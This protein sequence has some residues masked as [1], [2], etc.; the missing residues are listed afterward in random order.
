M[1]QFKKTGAPGRRQ[2][3]GGPHGPLGTFNISV[4]QCKVCQ[5]PRRREIDMMIALGWSIAQTR[6]H[7]NEIVKA[8]TGVDDYFKK[9]SMENHAANHLS[10]RDAA[11]AR[12]LERRAELEGI[13]VDKV[14]G[15]IFTKTGVAESVILRGM[16]AMQSGETT[17]EPKE[18]LAAIDVLMKLEEKRSVVAE[19]VM[20]REIRAFM[21]AVKK[22]VGEDSP[23]WDQIMVDY[24]VELG[25]APP[26]Q[27]AIEGTATR[28][29]D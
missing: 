11:V 21:K 13:D 15:F 26:E 27:A 10:A 22:N 9:S 2:P 8:E 6:R 20:L 29:E 3:P 18:I 19:E 14:E 25:E 5:D 1:A 17:V 16:E 12:I 4:P 7:W 24:K 23:L 28:T